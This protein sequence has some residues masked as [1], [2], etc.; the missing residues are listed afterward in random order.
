MKNLKLGIKL[1]GGFCITALIVVVV[2]LTAIFQQGKLYH[3]VLQVAEK[4]VPALEKVLN[5]KMEAN[6]T[7][8]L[9]RTLLSPYTSKEQRSAAHQGLLD[10]RSRYGEAMEE[11]VNL[12]V[13]S[14]VTREWDAFKTHA[15]KWAAANSRAVELSRDLIDADLVNVPL[16]KGNMIQVEKAHSTLLSRINRLILFGTP[17]EGGDDGHTCSLAKWLKNPSTTNQEILALIRKLTPVHLKLHEHVAEVKALFA[18][19]KVFDARQK[20]EKEL[21][22]VSGQVFDFLEKIRGIIDQSYDKYSEMNKV[23]LEDA[24]VYQVKTIEAIDAIVEKVDEHTHRSMEEA[25]DI[26]ATGRTINIIGI[27]AGTL[28][29]IFLGFVLTLAIT[30][31]VAKGVNLAQ[32][33]AQGDMTQRLDIDQKDEIGVLAAS[34]NGMAGNLRGM[35][36]DINNG[37]VDVNDTSATLATIANQMAA[38]AEDTA[39]RS[40]QV[41]A[42]AEEMS[43]NQDSV[44]AAMEQTS[45]NVNMV[46]SAAEEMT[47]TINEIAENSGKA[48]NI[49]TQAVN[50]SQTASERVSELGKAANEINKVTEAI[51]EISEQTNLLAL[52]ATIEAARAGEAGKGFAVVANEIK[53]LA[54]ETAE[55]TLDINNK[56]RSIQD[57]TGVTVTEINEISSIIA[58]VD[59]IVATIAT[60]VREQTETTSEIA[61]NVK[62]ASMGI[63]E[64]NE[65]VAQSSLVS[66]EISNDIN[67]VNKRAGQIQTASSKVTESAWQLAGIAEKLKEMMDKFTV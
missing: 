60:S 51:A 2:G 45:V 7:V 46:A 40:S 15:Q 6:S 25:E 37:V 55:A 62:Q 54:R 23:L 56:I 22:P 13:F 26:A 12:P 65:N 47:A 52:N 17:F 19:G 50:Q 1:T 66:A 24:V 9:M 35:I 4:D 38:G 57:A 14:S 42:A 43:S 31:P 34:L 21:Y 39:T 41:A 27:V 44:A 20:M 32:M 30:R 29:A 18:A 3:Q 28:V 8:G 33:M 58:D 61:E 59:Q 5:I 64:V 10:A 53:E 16:L 48:K 11:F 63:G 67:E 36:T 49:T